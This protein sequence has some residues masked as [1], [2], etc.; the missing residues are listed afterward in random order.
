MTLKSILNFCFI[1]LLAIS[2]SN[3]TSKKTTPEE[4]LLNNQKTGQNLDAENPKPV[5]EF[6]HSTWDFGQIIEGEKVTHTFKFKNTGNATLVVSSCNASC[7]CTTPKCPRDP[8]APG[9][10]GEVQIQFDSQNKPNAQTKNVT[11]YANTVPPDNVL[12][13]KAFVIPN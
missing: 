9:E 8:V 4:E 12:T 11:I 6:E 5:M 10:S 2:L 13:F 7:G 1:G 3:C